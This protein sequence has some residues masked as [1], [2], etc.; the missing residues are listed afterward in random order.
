M[1]GGLLTPLGGPPGIGRQTVGPWT[2]GQKAPVPPMQAPSAPQGTL[3]VHQP[4]PHQPATPYQQAAQLQSQ[5]TAPHEQPVQPSSQPATLYQQAMQLPRRSAGRGLLARPTSDRATPAAD[6]TTPDRGRQQTRG[7]GLR[8]RS[9]SHHRR[10]RGIATNAPSTVTQGESQFQPGRRSR[11]G[12]LDPA[13]IAAKYRTSGWRRDLEHV[14]KVYYKHTIQTP[15]REAEWA[16]A[17]ERFFDHLTPRKAEVV[18]I[19]EET[20]LSYMPYIAEEFHR[21]TG[22]RLNDLPEFTLWIKRGSYFHWLLVERGQVHECPHLIG[23]PLPKWPQLKP[24]ES[25]EE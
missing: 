7:Q 8:G 13:E 19:K 1:T 2:L 21:A 18:A 10:G 3:P 5:P 14:L 4:R 12:C 22:L 20:P 6:H 25:R 11:P 15:Y 24:S 16:R 9:T 23:A 17:R